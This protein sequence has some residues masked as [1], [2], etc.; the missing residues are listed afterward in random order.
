VTGFVNRCFVDL[1]H[2]QA[3]EVG[4][5][6]AVIT[7]LSDGRMRRHPRGLH[8]A[9]DVIDAQKQSGEGGV[10]HQLRCLRRA[11]SSPAASR[12]HKSE[13][14]RPKQTRLHRI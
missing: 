10:G 14:Q 8:D 6:I 12:H 13:R 9:V 11:R 4:Q 5:E 7:H 2:A 1:P 3:V